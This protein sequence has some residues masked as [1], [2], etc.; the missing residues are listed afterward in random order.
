MRINK[1][2]LL[3]LFISTAIHTGILLQGSRFNSLYFKNKNPEIKVSYLKR[4]EDKKERPKS[5]VARVSGRPE[6]FKFPAKIIANDSMPPRYASVE[7]EK[8]F[9]QNK[10]F[11]SAEQAFT[12]PSLIRGEDFINKKKISF[13]SVDL[14][15]INNPSYISY[16]QIVREK[17]RRAAYQNY[18]RTEEG[19]IY[20][21][22][23]IIN[24]GSLRDVRIVREKST[25]S[26]YLTGVALKS[27]NEASP[28][29]LFPKELDYKEL[30]FNVI[31]SF[32][33]E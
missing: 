9:R 13:P 25:N 33:I 7:R 24:N 6:I 16:Y 29:P 22:F 19:E 26:Q 8:E 14:D 32:E 31:I 20:L 23:I 3:A 12:K 28:F 27:I 18:S 11:P 21:S 5:S 10:A 1:I 2:F 30:T 4:V 15:K 17:I